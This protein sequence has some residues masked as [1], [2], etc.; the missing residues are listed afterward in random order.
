MQDDALLIVVAGGQRYALPR[1]QVES[2]QRVA[3]LGVPALVGLLGRSSD[4]PQPY[5]V[6]IAETSG[7][8]L[9]VE[10][11]DL[12]ELLPHLPLPEWIARLANP[13]VSG[14]VIHDDDLLPLID[15]LQLAHEIGQTGS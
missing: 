8:M 14:L 13:A 9:T 3:A 6:T 12:R 15:L 7:A 10:H 2:L 11:A 4:A 5:L 1:R